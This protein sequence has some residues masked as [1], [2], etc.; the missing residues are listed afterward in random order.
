MHKKAVDVIL[1]Q[2]TCH[3]FRYILPD[4]FTPFSETYPSKFY[5]S[6]GDNKS[7]GI[8]CFVKSQIH[9]LDGSVSLES[10]R[11][12]YIQLKH[13]DFA[14]IVHIYHVYNYTSNT[15][16]SNTLLQRLILHLTLSE[17]SSS[18]SVFIVG[19]FNINTNSSA[20]APPP[21]P[22]RPCSTTS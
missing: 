2:E 7:D 20:F 15:N 17:Y 16:N 18:D 21:P 9:I 22:G 8:I 3:A 14:N 10:G 5:S 13:D 19:D 1:L 12:D 11:I 4:K 6:S